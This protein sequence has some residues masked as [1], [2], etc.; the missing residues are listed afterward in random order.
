MSGQQLVARLLSSV[1]W[2]AFYAVAIGTLFLAKPLVAQT[3]G[4]DGVTGG[5]SERVLYHPYLPKHA[6]GQ[7]SSVEIFNFGLQT[8][9]FIAQFYDSVGM[10]VKTVSGT[11]TPA[12]LYQIDLAALPDL[13]DG[14]Y[15][16]T[17]DGS[18]PLYSVVR[19]LTPKRSNST[20][21]GLALYLGLAEPRM[22]LAFAPVYG[23]SQG[24]QL[25]LMNRTT[26]A[27]TVQL[28]YFDYSSHLIITSTVD[29]DP[30]GTIQLPPPAKLPA[31]FSGLVTAR[32]NRSLVG[33]LVQQQSDDGL[34][35][36]PAQQSYTLAVRTAAT[37]NL[38]YPLPRLLHDL[39]LGG[40]PRNSTALVAFAGE[41]QAQGNV[42]LFTTGGWPVAP[43]TDFTLASKTTRQVPLDN[44]PEPFVS[45]VV[46]G[47]Q[48]LYVVEQTEYTAPSPYATAGYGIA[49]AASCTNRLPLPLVVR[50][51]ARYSVIYVQNIDLDTADITITYRDRK[52][53]V[54]A[55][56]QYAVPGGGTQQYDLRQVAGL[57]DD[58][59]GSAEV[60]TPYRL[61]C[62]YVD[63]FMVGQP[64]E[65]SAVT[66]ETRLFL[67]AVLG[68]N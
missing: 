68:Q 29:L 3:G 14:T 21:G 31:P 54:Q 19:V 18:G 6:A 56:R 48:P 25:V 42:T 1:G 20:V 64:A 17:L 10:P 26:S 67:P 34:E 61:L 46:T 4:P 5:A 66:L 12:E 37:A 36:I 11:L 7:Q 49:D 2:L 57:P 35:I 55:I 43:E 52:G 32:S 50:Q 38:R 40:G 33:L 62:A 23:S 27:A 60:F 63:E 9:D 58:F 24:S 16:L 39:D 13:A 15:A 53:V 22:D 65:N 51:P 44:S 30:L 47:D 41:G 45:A 59:V 8:S 28:D